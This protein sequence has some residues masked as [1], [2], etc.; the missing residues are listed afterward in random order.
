[1]YINSHVIVVLILPLSFMTLLPS[2]SAQSYV[3]LYA[4]VAG[5]FWLS[6]AD[7][8]EDALESGVT[9]KQRVPSLA[10]LIEHPIYGKVL[11]DLGLRK[12][13]SGYPPK[14]QSELE[15]EGADMDVPKDVTDLLSEGGV[16]PEDI[17]AVIWSHLHF[18]HIGD[19]SP[20]SNAGSVLIVGAES[21]QYIER[22]GYPDD[23][24]SRW[25]PL[26]QGQKIFYVNFTYPE[27][28]VP[29]DAGSWLSKILSNPKIRTVIPIGEFPRGID[30]FS[31]GS[32]YLLD[33]PGHYPGHLNAL[34]RVAPNKFVLLAADCCHNRLCYDP[35][36]R[37]ISRNNH[38]HIETA[39][40]TV[41]YVKKMAKQDGVIVILSHEKERVEEDGM[42]LFPN[43]LNSWVVEECGKKKTNA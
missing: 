33:A 23:P 8:F 25:E 19:I 15:E 29:E 20:F 42:P 41:G 39:R 28:T 2:D 32:L 43:K 37:L 16:K 22:K 3:N 27:T 26:P 6:D 13:G 17:N 4:L 18:D 38:L 7:A 35:G 34:A 21:K 9:N 12:Y 24:D 30:V 31:D 1:M 14:L 11:F 5:T 40:E 36:E 10:F